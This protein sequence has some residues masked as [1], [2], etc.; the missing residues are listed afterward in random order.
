MKSVCGCS[1][2]RLSH[3]CDGNGYL[4][5]QHFDGNGTKNGGVGR[6]QTKVHGTGNEGICVS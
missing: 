1:G 6:N 5:P 3:C 2:G 4:S